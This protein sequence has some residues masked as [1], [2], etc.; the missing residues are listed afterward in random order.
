MA[1][2]VLSARKAAMSMSRA[3]SPPPLPG[4]AGS[5]PGTTGSPPGKAGLPGAVLDEAAHAGLGILGGEQAREVQPL[6]LQP[7]VE[8]GPPPLVDGLLGPPQRPRRAGRE[9]LRELDRGRLH[10]GVRDH[11]VDQADGQRLRRADE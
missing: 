5:E 6:D 11:L 10:L 3:S 1:T 7:S 2:S 8:V 9:A 4:T